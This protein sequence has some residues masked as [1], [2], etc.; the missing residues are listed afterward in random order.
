MEAHTSKFYIFFVMIYKTMTQTINYKHFWTRLGLSSGTANNG[1][2]DKWGS[3]WKVWGNFVL[4]MKLGHVGDP[5][6]A[7]TS[8][9]ILGGDCS[10][11]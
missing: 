9:L 6:S 10:N 5:L 1:D 4:S 2:R 7:L 8:I 3:D 11:F